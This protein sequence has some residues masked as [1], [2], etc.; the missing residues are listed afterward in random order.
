MIFAAASSASAGWSGA[1]LF[2]QHPGSSLEPLGNAG[3]RRAVTGTTVNPLAPASP[4]FVD[5]MN[6]LEIT[7]TGEGLSIEAANFFRLGQGANRALVGQELIQFG[8]V[9]WTTPNRAVLQDLLRGRGGS[10]WAIAAHIAGEPFILVDEALVP[11]DA[12]AIGD[13]SSA[14]ITATGL[15]DQAPVTAAINAYGTTRRPLTPVHGKAARMPDGSIVLSWVRRSRGL[16]AWPD[17][18]EIPLNEQSESYE[19]LVEDSEFRAMRWIV[20]S[21][22]LTVGADIAVNLASDST[23]SIFR[24]AQLGNS[25]ASI[26]LAIPIPD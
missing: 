19:V 12:T 17:S 8:S 2:V 16:Y 4:H 21:T 9:T 6:H 5:R 13:A 20:G 22:T 24:V 18:V 25:A 3:R 26:A 15:G 14:L 7:L 1:T 11:L 10:E 23:R